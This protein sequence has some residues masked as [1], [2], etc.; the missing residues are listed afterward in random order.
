MNRKLIASAM[1][2]FIEHFMKTNCQSPDYSEM[3]K[4]LV[5]IFGWTKIYWMRSSVEERLKRK[6][7]SWWDYFDKHDNISWVKMIIKQRGMQLSK[8]EPEETYKYDILKK[9]K[10]RATS[11]KFGI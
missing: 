5:D 4:D 3:K 8:I 10:I 7:Y 6:G 2:N 9:W 11:T 1:E